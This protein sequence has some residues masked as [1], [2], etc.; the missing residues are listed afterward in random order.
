MNVDAPT[1]WAGSHVVYFPGP[2]ENL[3]RP[4]QTIPLLNRLE[5]LLGGSEA[6]FPERFLGHGV[7]GF[8]Q[9]AL[10]QWMTLFASPRLTPGMSARRGM[11]D[12]AK[13]I[14]R[15]FDILAFR[16]LSAFCP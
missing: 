3:R 2:Y 1:A 10:D 7:T 5:K 13:T 11:T 6:P 8:A 14:R 16:F 12:E 9:T 15:H 4:V